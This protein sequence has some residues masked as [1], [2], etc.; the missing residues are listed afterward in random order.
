[1]LMVFRASGARLLVAFSA[2]AVAAAVPTVHAQFAP[3]APGTQVHDPSALKPP[4]GAHVAIVEF[5]DM[6]CPD[7]ARANPLLK[8]ASEKYHI[9]W[10]R[11]DFPLAQHAWSF[12]AAVNARWFDE[13]AG[14]KVGDEYRD[15]IF[16]NQ[17]SFG[18]NAS[19]MD[20][21][22]QKF[23][24]EHKIAFPFNV[25]PQGKLTAAVKA[26][27][28]LGQRIGIEHTPTIWV[29]T[30]QSKG[31]PFVEV[32]DRTKLYQMIDQAIADTKG[33]AP[34][35]KPAAKHPQGK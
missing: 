11:H 24:A 2:L 31:A 16:A 29:V 14:K 7:C 30:S 27:Y 21:F 23:A 13:K 32:V 22:T 17:P 28:A 8:E 19:S 25:D 33:A 34:A 20:D 6:E 12:Q 1:M 35:G 15:A 4:A 3:P 5:E 9:P 10:V 18:D 26:D